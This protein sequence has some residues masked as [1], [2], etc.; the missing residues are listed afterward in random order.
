MRWR[1]KERAAV[2]QHLENRHTD[3]V[4]PKRARRRL[5][6]RAE[7]DP[8]PVLDHLSTLSAEAVQRNPLLRKL[9]HVATTSYAA[10][11]WG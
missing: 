4:E 8:R 10:S 6:D 7:E 2:V 3:R 5:F 11:V 1:K 9:R